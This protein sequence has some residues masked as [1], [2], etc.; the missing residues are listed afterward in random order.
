[1]ECLSDG[2]PQRGE[3]VAVVAPLGVEHY[4]R[5][6]SRVCPADVGVG[7]GAASIGVG[8]GL[9]EGLGCVWV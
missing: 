5:V 6:D 1:M 7:V 9:G 8:F 2:V 4:G 3:F